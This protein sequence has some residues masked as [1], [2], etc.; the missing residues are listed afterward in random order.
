MRTT[1]PKF[2][3][4]IYFLLP[5]ILL[6][7]CNHSPK[8]DGTAPAPLFPQPKAIE[9][10]PEGGY[11]INTVTGDSIKPIIFY[12]GDTLISGVPIRAKPKLIHP[13]SVAKPKSYIVNHALLTSKNAH[14][15]RHKIP[16]NIPTFPV[17]H[18]QL[19]KVKFGE[20]NQDFALLKSTGDTIPT[21]VPILAKGRSVKTTQPPLTKASP[22]AFKDAAIANLQYLDVDQ[23]MTIPY[24]LSIYEDRNGNL[25]FG[26]NGGGVSRYDGA[27]F[28]HYTKKEGLSN[29][30]VLSILEDRSGNLWFGTNGGGVSRYDGATFEHFT[31]KEGL[32][33]NR[34]RAILEDRSGNLWFGTSGGGVSRYDGAT[35]V[36]FTV[37]EGLSHNRVWSIYEDRNGNLWFGTVG[38]GVSRYDGATF[39]HFTVKEGLSN[40][41]VL[42]ILE[43]S[44][45][46]LWFGTDEGGVS[47]YDGT[48]FEHYT[49]KEGL[50]NN[51]VWSILEDRSGNLWFGT[52]GGGLSRYDGAIFEHYTEN[53]GL[54]NNY[55][56]SIYEDRSGSLWFGTIYGGVNRYDG[57]TFKHFTEN[58]GL[59]NNVVPSI[60]EDRSGN[61][62]FGTYG[63]GLS[64]YDGATFTHYTE[65]EG[66]S[67]NIIWSILEDKSGN[68]FTSTERGL[69]NLS[70]EGGDI[71]KISFLIN[72]F[73]KRDGLK[74]VDFISDNAFIDSKN[75]AWW[76]SSKSLT[77]LDL[78]KFKT[79]TQIPQPILK[80]LDIN[81]KFIDYRN[82]S[83]G[84]GN[85]ITF[86]GVQK[87]ENYPL[88]LELPYH[89]NH[90]TF[91]YAAID[92]KAPHKIQYSH[93]MLGLNKNWS[94]ASKETKSDYRN[95]PYGTYTLQIRAIGESGA[96]S[97]PI[98]Y[99]FTINPPW[100]RTWWAYLIYAI[101]FALV[102]IRF[103]RWRT[104]RIKKLN[105]ALEEKVRDR[106]HQLEKKSKDLSQSLENLKST[107]AQ[108]IQSEK[109]ASL[110]ELTAGIAHEIQNPLNFVNNFSEVSTELVD[111][112]KAELET[113][114][115]EL[116]TE[117]SNDLKQNLEKINHHG[118]RAGDIVKGMLQHSSSRSGVKEPTDI[119]ALAD[120]YLRLAYHG[121]RA[122]DKSFNATMKTDFDESIGK[123]NVVPQ[124]IG[125]VILNLITNAFYA[126]TDRKKQGEDGYEPTVTVSTKLTANSQLLIAVK[127][128]GNGIPD[129]IKEKIFQPFFTTKPTGQGTGLGLSLSYDIVKAHGGE[130]KVE[131]QDG[132]GTEFI[133][134]LPT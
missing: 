98:D 126:V 47:R 100:W 68:L 70:I 10:N 76:G 40:N 109:M 28:E 112:M 53:E 125:R 89:N 133:I 132:E 23:G 103:I 22:P 79:S 102:V 25:W 43:D 44:S 55:V 9:A 54:S 35:F 27:N 17:D 33:N 106:T 117:I 93:R 105:V 111:E 69:N 4:K 46:N 18:S 58:E 82:I 12:N 57:A 50:S 67:N 77:M 119:N 38:G 107:Q 94:V 14:P 45:G 101:L 80:H 116:V 78:S 131:S 87:F 115:L 104:E 65:K 20:G 16:E 81:E 85:E 1:A 30:I 75:R 134:F 129:S 84:L 2:F 62:W 36:H 61:L 3:K 5:L 11:L 120:E 113:G 49:E 121:L 66:L 37:K 74:G 99:A 59:S 60:Y 13:D 31:V 91:H 56:V 8:D 52:N 95:L 128:N 34:V 108:L 48:T 26:T 24:V 90:L 127:D 72:I 7:A 42:S 92:W 39:E 63:G 86:N 41:T 88:N 110:G 124:D 15:N 6:A 130:I 19:K 96:W 83:D 71:E 29:D 51:I 32:S 73:S 122:K 64:R 118:K 123:I 97:K 114:N 21:G